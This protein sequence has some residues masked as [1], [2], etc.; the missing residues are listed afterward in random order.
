MMNDDVNRKT[1][2]RNLFIR[3]H[4]FFF[5]FKR[6]KTYPSNKSTYC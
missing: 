5:I 2:Q 6:S 1:K 4:T 3:I